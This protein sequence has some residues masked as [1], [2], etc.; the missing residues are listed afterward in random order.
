MELVAFGRQR[1]DS[2]RA[3]RWVAAG[4][5]FCTSREEQHRSTTQGV[6][7][8][9]ECRKDGTPKGILAAL[10]SEA[11]VKHTIGTQRAEL[12]TKWGNGSGQGH[13]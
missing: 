1:E 13:P 4:Y 5:I 3:A 8:L 6:Y 9:R 10:I 12:A 11:S 7:E 2:A